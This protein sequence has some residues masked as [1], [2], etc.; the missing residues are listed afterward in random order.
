MSLRRTKKEPSQLEIN[1]LTSEM[2]M[3]Q[4]RA[5]DTYRDMP[6][7]FF[8]HGR[9]IPKSA[10]RRDDLAMFYLMYNGAI[11]KHDK[12][13]LKHFRAPT[14]RKTSL[15]KKHD[16]HK[17]SLT[18]DHKGSLKKLQHNKV[19]PSRKDSLKRPMRFV[20]PSEKKPNDYSASDETDELTDDMMT[21]SLDHPKRFRTPQDEDPDNDF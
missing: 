18:K 2:T 7:R 16:R 13:E 17:L 3:D 21:W 4:I 12:K 11:I 14:H 8:I 10:L 9:A 19:I 15:E 1:N 20:L 5:T 6:T